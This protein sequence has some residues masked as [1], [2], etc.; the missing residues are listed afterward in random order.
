MK[1][2]LTD[3]ERKAIGAPHTKV[4]KA[5]VYFGNALDALDAGKWKEAN[6]YFGMALKE[7]PAFDLARNAAGMCPGADSPDISAVLNMSSS[8]LSSRIEA[9][10]NSAVGIRTGIDQPVTEFPTGGGYTGTDILGVDVGAIG[11]SGINSEIVVPASETK[12]PV[13]QEYTPGGPTYP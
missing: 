9:S 5:L 10:V 6:D 1:I 12:E 4:Y 8:K 13:Y 11:V 7:D 3:E 2:E